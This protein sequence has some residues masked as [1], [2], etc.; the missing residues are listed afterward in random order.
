MFQKQNS[1][2]TTTDWKTEKQWE[3]PKVNEK[4]KNDGRISMNK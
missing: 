2:D 3:V 1:Q 4:F